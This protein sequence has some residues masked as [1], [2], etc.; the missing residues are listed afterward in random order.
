LKQVDQLE[1]NFAKAR[2]EGM[3]G[4]TN[5]RSGR[6][7]GGS[8]MAAIEFLE[9]TPANDLRQPQV[10]ALGDDKKTSEVFREYRQ[11]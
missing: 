10:I 7:A 11:N 4:Q 5:A 1:K 9:W 6:S 8:M 2:P 3:G